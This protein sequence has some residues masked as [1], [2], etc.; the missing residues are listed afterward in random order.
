M[1]QNRSDD[2]GIDAASPHFVASLEKGLAV[3]TCFGREATRLTPSEVAR[4]IGTSPASARRSLV[5]LQALGYLESDGKRFQLA[6]K[7]LLIAHA[8]LASRQLPSVAQPLLD[9]LSERT[10]ESASIGQW[11]GNDVIIVGRST[12]RRC[13]S[14]GLG[15]GSRLPGHCSALGRAL[16]SGL[17]ATD[18]ERRIKLMDRQ[19]LTGATQVDLGLLVSAVEQCREVGHAV[20]DGE[21]EPA[22]RSLAVPLRG[23]DARVIAAMSIS[24][25]A[26]RM[27]L[28]EFRE[29]FL[30]LLSKCRDE[31]AR[32]LSPVGL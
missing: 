1:R 31:L 28:H 18:A 23:S 14:T 6:P 24:V 21:I 13:L 2:R 32:R 27:N 11:L 29:A 20:S 26:D 9:M 12:A 17:S 19:K 8:Y 25:R 22:V 10:R 16:L 30:P 5:T 7:V 15:V 4:H 3:L